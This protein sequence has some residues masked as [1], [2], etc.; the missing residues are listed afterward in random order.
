MKEQNQKAIEVLEEVKKK[1]FGTPEVGNIYKIPNIQDAF[2][3]INNKIE[4]LKR[5][6]K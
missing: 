4:E 3:I 5:G 1:I 2:Y 6:E